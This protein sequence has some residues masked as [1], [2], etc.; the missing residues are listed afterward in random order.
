MPVPSC[1]VDINQELERLQQIFNSKCENVESC[2]DSLDDSSARVKSILRKE[3]TRT[4]S[5][6]QYM[7]TETTRLLRTTIMETLLK[8]KAEAKKAKKLKQVLYQNGNVKENQANLMLKLETMVEEIE[9]LRRNMELVCEIDS[10]KI[11]NILKESFYFKTVDC[12]P[13]MFRLETDSVFS[14]KPAIVT[15]NPN[16]F[17]SEFLLNAIEVSWSSVDPDIENRS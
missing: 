3:Y 6:I 11:Q 1:D 5:M 9:F 13:M 16:G 8:A 17:K 2:L 15:S 7:E 12:D 14:P 4:M 10:N